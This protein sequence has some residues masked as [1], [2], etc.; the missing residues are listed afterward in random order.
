MGFYRYPGS[1][2]TELWIEHDYFGWAEP[3]IP[4]FPQYSKEI[5]ETPGFYDWDKRQNVIYWTG[6]IT[7]NS[8]RRQY[9]RCANLYPDYILVDID[10]FHIDRSKEKRTFF[11]YELKPHRMD[12][13]KQI[14]YKYLIYFPGSAWSSSLKR[15]MTAGAVLVMPSPNP[16]ETLIS[17][18]LQEKCPDCYLT[19][20]YTSSDDMCKELTKIVKIHDRSYNRTAIAQHNLM[21]KKLM[22]FVFNEFNVEKT[23]AYMFNTLTKISKKQSD[24]DIKSVIKSRNLNRIDCATLKQYAKSNVFETGLTWQYDLWY[25]N[26]CTMILSG[27]YL[28]LLAL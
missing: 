25:D 3:W 6:H 4:P 24:K 10:S 5:K 17:K 15:I 23:I 7:V 28:K 18:S 16:H 13:R 11:G 20:N 27:D 19:Y 8:V 1:N 22:D 26:N 12:L 14:K 21:R 2:E 9:G